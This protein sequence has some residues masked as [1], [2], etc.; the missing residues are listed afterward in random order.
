MTTKL[1]I[2][3]R[4]CIFR[5]KFSK[6]LLQTPCKAILAHSC[7]RVIVNLFAN[8]NCRFRKES[9]LQLWKASE[10]YWRHSLKLKKLNLVLSSAN[11]EQLVYIIKFWI[12]T[13]WKGSWKM[14]RQ[15]D[16]S[17]NWQRIYANFLYVPHSRIILFHAKKTLS[18][19]KNFTIVFDFYPCIRFFL[20][21]TSR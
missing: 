19:I 17:L 15:N 14:S 1:W 5:E 20:N 2:V 12:N 21:Q 18:L 13:F 10:F 3:I 6:F 7:R 16:N 4:V 8:C 11:L 9:I